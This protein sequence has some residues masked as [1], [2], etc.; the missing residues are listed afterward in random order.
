MC[1]Y[2]FQESLLPDTLPFPPKPSHSQL[3]QTGYTAETQNKE[4]AFAASFVHVF[5][6]EAAGKEPAPTTKTHLLREKGSALGSTK[7]RRGTAAQS[8]KRDRREGGMA[9]PLQILVFPGRIHGRVDRIC[10]SLVPLG[11]QCKSKV[12]LH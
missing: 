1:I 6:R 11:H 3:V 2:Y 4:V 8:K 9:R 7:S 10:P 12:R 5:G